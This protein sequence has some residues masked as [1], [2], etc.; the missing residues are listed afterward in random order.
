MSDDYRDALL[1]AR[2]YADYRAMFALKRH[3]EFPPESKPAPPTTYNNMP[4]GDIEDE[5]EEN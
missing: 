5:R 4:T 1:A 3:G 2:L